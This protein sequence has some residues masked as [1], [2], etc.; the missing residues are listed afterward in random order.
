MGILL[1]YCFIF[2][3]KYVNVPC[4]LFLW[5]ECFVSCFKKFL[6]FINRGNLNQG[7]NDNN[8]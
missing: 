1:M 7:N 8:I 6:I 3:K 2:E 5:N 4:M